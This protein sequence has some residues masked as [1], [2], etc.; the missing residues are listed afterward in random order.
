MGIDYSD[1]GNWMSIA[2]YIGGVATIIKDIIIVVIVEYI[3]I[4]EYIIAIK[5]VIMLAIAIVVVGIDDSDSLKFKEFFGVDFI[6][7]VYFDFLA[8]H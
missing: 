8:F 4:I 3:I 6:F 2:M 5:F 1:D 7:I